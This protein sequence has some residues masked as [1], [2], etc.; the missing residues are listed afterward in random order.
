MMGTK[1]SGHAKASNNNLPA[2]G[3][4][5]ATRDLGGGRITETNEIL[6]LL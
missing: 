1:I 3:N 4:V 6:P 2:M 5:E